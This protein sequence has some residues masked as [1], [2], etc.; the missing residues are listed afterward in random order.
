[1]TRRLERKA[2]ELH[3][4]L[5]VVQTPAETLPFPDASFDVVVSTLV[6]CTVD[7]QLTTLAELRRVLVPGGRLLFLE[8]VRSDERRLAR[9]QDRLNRINRV[10]G[11][12]CNCNRSTLE[13]VR[14]A[15][16]KI[17]EVEQES[18]QKAPPILRP[19]VVGVAE[20]P[21]WQRDR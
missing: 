18:L 19:L 7:D 13:T 2:R 15:G 16:F 21:S 20:S 10:M 14:A 5:E 4:E 17:V 3:I 11:A 1:M 9:W 12:G 6:L 8:H